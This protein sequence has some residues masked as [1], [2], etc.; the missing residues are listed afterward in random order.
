[1]ADQRTRPRAGARGAGNASVRAGEAAAFAIAG[2]VKSFAPSHAATR[3]GARAG[4]GCGTVATISR[5]DAR[6]RGL[7]GGGTMEDTAR[8]SHPRSWRCPG[9]DLRR[10]A[11]DAP[12]QE[13]P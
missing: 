2:H 9:R 6:D 10:R 5:I 13:N 3:S 12:L 1:M 8:R 11:V 4:P 7:A